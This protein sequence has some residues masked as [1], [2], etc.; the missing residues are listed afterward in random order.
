MSTPDDSN[1][2]EDVEAEDPDM[3]DKSPLELETLT[4]ALPD[5]ATMPALDTSIRPLDSSEL[6]APVAIKTDPDDPSADLPVTTLTDPDS[7]SPD[8]DTSP[9]TTS[10]S[11]LPS[12]PPAADAILTAPDSP[13][14]TTLT[15]LPDTLT[16]PPTPELPAPTARLMEPPLPP[17]LMP[18]PITILP[19]DDSVA[20]PVDTATPP[21]AEDNDSAFV[22]ATLTE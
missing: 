13:S 14:A 8:P 3:S 11:P 17:S 21:S 10:T 16:L 5:M 19:D 12:D 6:P 9:V 7:P 4:P 20:L 18:L 15:E 1:T 22:L 2:E